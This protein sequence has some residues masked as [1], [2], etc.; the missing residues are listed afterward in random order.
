MCG[1][2][3]MFDQHGERQANRDLV[4]RMNDSI[5]HRGPDG[6]GYHFDSGIALGHRR[7]AV[8]DLSQGQQPMKNR[9]GTVVVVY[10]GEIYNFRELRQELQSLGHDFRTKSDSEVIV[11]AWEEWREDCVTRFS[12][13]FAF[14]LWDDTQK[15]LFL[16]RDRRGKK[17]LYYAVLE[18]GWIIFGSELKALL[19]DQRL[20]RR[21]DPKAVENYFTY[22][23]VPDPQTIFEGVSKLA[24]AH[25]LSWRRG[26]RQRLK[27]YWRP[28]LDE[29]LP[30]RPEELIPIL[31]QHLQRSVEAR[32]ISDVPLG[33]FLSGGV[34]SGAIVSTM[35]NLTGGPPETFTVSFAEAD[36]DEAPHAQMVAARCSTNHHVRET[37]PSPLADLGQIIDHFDEPFADSSAIPTYHISAFARQHVTVVL[38]GDGGDEV[39]AG[40]RRYWWHMTE[41][42][43]RSAMPA[44]FRRSFFGTLAA[45][46]PKLDWAPQA[47][48]AKTAFHELSHDSLD[49]YRNSVGLLSSQMRERIFTDRFR[50]ELQGYSSTEVL[51]EA[52]RDCQ[53]EHP[54]LQAQHLDIKTY[55]PGDILVKVD[56]ASMAHSLEARVPLLDHEFVAWAGQLPAKLKIK[57]LDRKWILRQA[58]AD[59]LPEETLARPKQGFS[60][61]LSRWLRGPLRPDVERAL[62]SESLVDTGLFRRE[63]LRRLLDQH[64]SRRHDHGV[65][66]WC[67]LVFAR[68]AER[69]L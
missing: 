39:F 63:S 21:L 47:F 58:L 34:D 29:T 1:F 28:V 30:A 61:P 41:E 25:S 9:D 5:I 66:L 60:V 16:A 48:R 38:S 49:G 33:A 6:E 31:R 44:G 67:L 23:Y 18:D 69:R 53:S 45:L 40:Y 64:L 7:L 8:I 35:A 12:G 68:F 13:M 24:P 19:L 26:G 52:L 2:V 54:L 10:N 62:M 59:R 43:I 15:T 36:F 17:P 37:Q 11:H 51:R 4:Q 27:S 22:G 46:Y 55:L 42:R 3:G 14:A 20:K 32:L 65:V 56:R 57:G 50:R